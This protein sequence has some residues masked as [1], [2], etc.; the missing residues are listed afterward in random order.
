[1]LE[2][3]LSCLVWPGLQA[4]ISSSWTLGLGLLL[5]VLG[6]G[7]RS[8]AMATAGTNFNHVPVKERRE[9]HVLV[10]QGIYGVLRH[11]AYFGFFWWAVGTQ[12]IVGNAVCFVA[13]TVVLWKFFHHRIVE[14]E[15]LLCAF[16]EDEYVR[17]RST[18]STG[19]P[20]IR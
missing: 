3:L 5:V 4:R 7:V 11:P 12:L 20:F 19:I 18:T 8:A 9:G 13:Y 16:F 6:Q 2:I 10:T 15:K 14:E 1:M 17:Y